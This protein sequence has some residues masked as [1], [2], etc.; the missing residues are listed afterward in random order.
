MSILDRSLSLG[1]PRS[2][3]AALMV[4][5]RQ[6][7]ARARE[8]G[9]LGELTIMA[10]VI[11]RVTK[12]PVPLKSE[13][14]PQP[15]FVMAQTGRGA[16]PI[17]MP[18]IAIGSSRVHRVVQR[19]AVGDVIKVVGELRF[20]PADWIAPGFVAHALVATRV[21]LIVRRS[22]HEVTGRS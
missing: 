21:L 5:R 2:V 7:R 10:T 14:S 12:A 11:C 15:V 20:A 9:E 4:P 18:V 6:V 8:T 1:T 17:E 19:L 22:G 13:A 3:N 16:G